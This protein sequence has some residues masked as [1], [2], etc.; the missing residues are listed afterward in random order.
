MLVLNCYRKNIPEKRCRE[1]MADFIHI[2]VAQTGAGDSRAKY[3]RNYLL[4]E[5]GDIV[6]E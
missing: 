2:V 3:F 6:M 4:N 5:I 1:S